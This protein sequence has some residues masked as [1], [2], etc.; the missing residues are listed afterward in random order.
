M[1]KTNNN[2]KPA[3]LQDWLDALEHNGSRPKANG[4]GFLAHCPAHED[5][6]PSLS[7][8]TGDKQPVVVKCFA[9]CEFEAIRAALGLSGDGAPRSAPPVQRKP[10]KPKT[11]QALPDNPFIKTYFY[12]TADGE[13]AFA[14]QRRTTPTGKTFSQ[15]RP[16]DGGLWLAE[17][18]PGLRPLY[19]LADIAKSTGRVAVVEGEKCVE[20]M[21]E[22]LPQQPVTTWAG[23]ADSWRRTDWESLAGREVSLLAD[24][25]TP[26]RTAMTGIAEHLSGL[27]CK[28]KIGLPDGE[29]GDD[30][31]DWLAID[32]AAA[33]K[34]VGELLQDYQPAG[35]DA[36]AGIP[37]SDSMADNPHFRILGLAGDAVAIRIR[38]GRILQRTRESLTQPATLIAIAPLAYWARFTESDNLSS[39]DG[40]KLGDTLIREADQLGQIDIS[41]IAGR[42]AA[43]V[44]SGDV[45]YHLGDRIFADGREMPLDE[46][47]QPWLAEPRLELPPAASAKELRTIADAVM[48]YRWATPDDG[49][50]LLGWIVAAIVGGALEW[51]PHLLLTAPAAQGKSWL[52]RHVVERLMGE[53]LIRIAD[54]TPAALARLTA[55]SS[56]PIAIDEAEPSSPWVLEL[57]KLLRVS[58]GAEGLR[59]R[60]D[61][62]TGGVVTQAPQIQRAIEFD[63]RSNPATRRRQPADDHSIRPAGCGLA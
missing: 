4:R 55:H 12:T 39:A 1:D 5:A 6:T 44:P 8:A 32:Q 2:T 19:L 48:A 14:V 57:L 52:L 40:R 36:D 49:R 61:A 45:V 22:V 30:I 38:A 24:A 28:I 58:S 42:G 20:A 54:A 13:I 56:L 34:R 43:R 37:A 31:A 25:D 17:S 7:I 3:T 59:V 53:L 62:T 9:G 10:A 11:P 33:L 15:W 46:D 50:R 26:G 35:P 63:R 27:G 47:G 23:G 29:S 51:R 60:A 41:K 21:H 16:A 18:A